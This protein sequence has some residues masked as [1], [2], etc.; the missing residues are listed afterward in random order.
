LSGYRDHETL[1]LRVEHNYSAWY[2][3]H[4]ITLQAGEKSAL[5][6]RK[7][8]LLNQIESLSLFDPAQSLALGM[9]DT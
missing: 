8:I 9:R 6:Y 5:A 1:D 7:V 4:G 3:S 2:D